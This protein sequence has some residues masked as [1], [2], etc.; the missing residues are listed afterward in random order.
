MFL[1][2]LRKCRPIE[3]TVI[4]LPVYEFIRSNSVFTSIFLETL[5]AEDSQICPPVTIISLS[6][7]LLT[8]ATSTSQARAIA[9]ASL[10]MDTLLVLTE[11]DAVLTVFS[12]PCKQY[13]RLCRQVCDSRYRC[14]WTFL[15]NLLDSVYHYSQHLRAQGVLPCVQYLI[16]VFSGYATTSTWDWKYRSMC[17]DVFLE[18]PIIYN[19]NRKCVWA[20]H[21]IIFYLQKTRVRLGTWDDRIA[22]V[23][24]I[25]W[26]DYTWKELWSALLG[27]L[28]FLS[29]K[30]ENL[31]STGGVEQLII[32]VRNQWICW[33]AIYLFDR[34]CYSWTLHYPNAKTFY[35]LPELCM[36]W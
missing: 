1:S 11:N 35:P 13:I 12:R 4:L 5:S 10:S 25:F 20:C 6:S 7:Y 16:A 26:T 36:N 15:A 24:L 14:L 27:L 8:H 32:E 22:C 23:G 18:S 31:V 34:L 33:P 3:A 21:R 28:H 2:W 19:W 29:S 30:L 9:Y 17:M